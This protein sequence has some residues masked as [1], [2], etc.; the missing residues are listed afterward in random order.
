MRLTRTRTRG[1]RRG[2]IRA[3]S[4]TLLPI[5]ALCAGGA[6]GATH[7]LLRLARSLG[8]PEPAR[9][10]AS[11]TDAAPAAPARAEHSP[12]RLALDL[13]A[14]P[15]A[16][17]T[18]TGV[19]AAVEDGRARIDLDWSSPPGA[20]GE[21][22]G[23]ELLISFGAPLGETSFADLPRRLSGWLEDVRYGYDTLLVVAAAGVRPRL[24]VTGS[25]VSILLEREKSTAAPPAPPAATAP[26]QGG[27]ES[28]QLRLDRLR[29]LLLARQ[30]D[31]EGARGRLAELAHSHPR[32]A[33]LL[34]NLAEM[35]T[36]LGRWRPAL[37]LYRRAIPLEERP[38]SPIQAQAQLLHDHGIQFRTAFDYADVQNADRQAI[39]R[40]DGRLPLDTGPD[41]GLTFKRRDLEVP[42]FA[43]VSGTTAPFSGERARA[44]LRAGFPLALTTGATLSLALAD[45]GPG[46]GLRIQHTGNA[47]TSG[48]QLVWRRPYWTLPEGVVE[49]AWISEAGLFHSGDLGEHLGYDAAVSLNRYGIDGRDD[50]ARSWS[51][52][53][54]LTWVFS[55][56]AP[57]LAV[58]YRL[59]TEHVSGRRRGVDSTGQAF[60]LLPLTSR[61]EHALELQWSQ[62]L[63]TYLRAD[64]TGGYVY[65]RLNSGGP[66]VD[67]SL[68]YEPLPDLEIGV[69]AGRSITSDRGGGNAVT[70][71]GAFVVLRR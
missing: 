22:H 61:E 4:C 48:A 49:D 38:A 39:T 1:D 12:L 64:A 17:P 59:D 41:L 57:Y 58:D 11:G 30:G 43:R 18:L 52:Q 29:A 37:G 10:P 60:D 26:P 32:D 63:T 46:L 8:T 14:A 6:V 2:R 67:V 23:R 55:A 20:R 70:R 71:V 36:R 7:P 47:G 15:R 69:H 35:E 21:R 54:G 25:R 42:A 31:V 50:V 53:A 40:L 5:L 16:A 27:G 3:F 9:S 66:Y 28:A 44:E 34:E 68:S 45:S 19:H 13:G 24:R 62:P 51:A 65:D 56:A 33:A